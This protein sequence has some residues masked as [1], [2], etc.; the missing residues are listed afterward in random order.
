MSAN[1]WCQ[2]IAEIFEN[3][4]IVSEQSKVMVLE[5]GPLDNGTAEQTLPWQIIFNFFFL[6]VTVWGTFISFHGL[7]KI[8]LILGWG[9][10]KRLSL[11]EKHRENPMK[12]PKSNIWKVSF[13][14][15]TSCLK[16]TRAERRRLQFN[17]AW[18]PFWM[19]DFTLSVMV[20]LLQTVSSLLLQ[21]DKISWA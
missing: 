21:N 16:I 12:S 19:H 5:I 14:S 7:W 11:T 9:V 3:G 1:N 4:S 13:C 10:L 8:L 6:A 15:F 18:L 17:W 20:L 2:R